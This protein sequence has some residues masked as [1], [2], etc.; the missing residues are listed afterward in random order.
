MNDRR[1][2]CWR[3]S[4]INFVK[5]SCAAI[6]LCRSGGRYTC[7]IESKK[8]RKPSWARYIHIDMIWDVAL[9]VMGAEGRI[10]AGEGIFLQRSRVKLFIWPS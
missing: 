3:S 8:T 4:E 7:P 2:G 1:E 6:G 9:S 10:A 5:R